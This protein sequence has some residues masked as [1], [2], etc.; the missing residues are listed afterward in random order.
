MSTQPNRDNA[1]AYVY[2]LILNGETQN[3]HEAA[4]A[5]SELDQAE[6]T[7]REL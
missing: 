2:E 6:L 5:I 3:A 7:R 4:Q 1:V